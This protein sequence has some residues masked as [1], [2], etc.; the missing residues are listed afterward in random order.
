[1][2]VF[3]ESEFV[4]SKQKLCLAVECILEKIGSFPAAQFGNDNFLRFK[5]RMQALL[6]L[7]HDV[8]F[9]K[10]MCEPSDVRELTVGEAER[11]QKLKVAIENSAWGKKALGNY[12]GAD[13]LAWKQYDACELLHAH[14]KFENFGNILCK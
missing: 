1:M 12:L 6:Y 7:Y 11:S 13:E 8:P 10:G 4:N 3:L 5:K 2:G 9:Y 14:G